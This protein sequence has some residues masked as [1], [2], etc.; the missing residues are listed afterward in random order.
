MG[1]LIEYVIT[2]L[3]CH[4]LYIQFYIYTWF[5]LLSGILPI[6]EINAQYNKL[7]LNVINR[8]ALMYSSYFRT[9]YYY[10]LNDTKINRISQISFGKIR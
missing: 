7:C 10:K 4:L 9:L 3:P 1:L 2:I 6:Q 8:V 5:F